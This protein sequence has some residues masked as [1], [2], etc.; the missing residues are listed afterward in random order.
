MACFGKRPRACATKSSGD[1]SEKHTATYVCVKQNIELLMRLSLLRIC[2]KN[3]SLLQ[4]IILRSHLLAL[5]RQKAFIRDGEDEILGSPISL[6]DF[7]ED[8]R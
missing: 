8:Q 3:S 7:A 6:P 5:L 4:G 1:V 2:S